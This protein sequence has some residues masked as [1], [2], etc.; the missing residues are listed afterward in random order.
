M[1]YRYAITLFGSYDTNN[2]KSSDEL[3]FAPRS[4][5]TYNWLWATKIV[6]NPAER[7]HTDTFNLDKVQLLYRSANI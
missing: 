4:C 7:A 6:E 3:S 5:I 2:G 1:N